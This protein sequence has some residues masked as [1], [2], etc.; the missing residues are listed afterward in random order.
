M[1]GH[2]FLQSPGSS[3]TTC[4]RQGGC[5]RSVR[6]LYFLLQGKISKPDVRPLAR[7]T[8][9]MRMGAVSSKLYQ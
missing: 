4:S 1:E 2:L 8:S 7:I 9:V 3:T 5:C 6:T